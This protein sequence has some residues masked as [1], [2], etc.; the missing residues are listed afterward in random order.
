MRYLEYYPTLL[1]PEQIIV[2]PDAVDLERF[3]A[4]SDVRVARLKSH[5]P[6]DVFTVGYSGHL[7]EGRGIDLILEL[8]E[9][10]PTINFILMGGEEVHIENWRRV[11]RNRELK[12]VT[13]IGFVPNAELPLYLAACDVLLMP[14]QQ[15]IQVQ[16]STI[17]TH[18]WMSPMKMFEYMAAKRLIISSD[19]P[20]LRTVL[21]Q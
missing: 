1:S 13:L 16:G 20:I 10:L 2:E 21:H 11:I 14:Y 17:S 5:L 6:E 8:V 19:F 12:N 7:Y 3:E 4:L 9:R 18:E 15:N